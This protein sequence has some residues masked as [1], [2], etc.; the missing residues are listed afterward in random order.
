MLAYP[1]PQSHCCRPGKGSRFAVRIPFVEPV[2]RDKAADN[3]IPATDPHYYRLLVVD[4]NEDAAESLA[5]LLR[6]QGHDV[7]TAHD[8]PSALRVADLFRPALVFMD[9]GMPSMDGY[10]VARRIRATPELAGTVLVALTGW[11]QQEDRRRS[12]DS[13]FD[14]HVVKPV[15]PLTLTQIVGGLASGVRSPRDRTTRTGA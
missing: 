5:I 14:H 8:G 2:E 1:R 13:G 11:G 9:I 6:V 15:D 10:E 7:M 12:I 4:D 3:P